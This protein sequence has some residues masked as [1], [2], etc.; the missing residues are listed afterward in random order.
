MKTSKRGLAIG[1]FAAVLSGGFPIY[2]GAQTS[3]NGGAVFAL[4]AGAEVA[5][6]AE[7]GLVTWM[8][9]ATGQ[10]LARSLAPAGNLNPEQAAAA[11]LNSQA[12]AFGLRTGSAELAATRS[13]GDDINHTFVRFQQQ[14]RDVPIIGAE[15]SVQLD[16]ARN[17]MSVNGKTVGDLDLSVQ[18]DVSA[19]DAL[20]TAL[21]STARA[22]RVTVNDL[23]GST[24]KLSIH[25]ARIMGGPPAPPALVWRI[26]VKGV[27]AID[28][29]ELVLVNAQNGRVAVQFNQT[30][31]A[32]LPENAKQ[33]VCDAANTT[34]KVPCTKAD[35]VTAPGSSAVGDV[36]NAF[37]YAEFTYDF[38]AKRFNRNSLDNKGLRLISTTRYRDPNHPSS[39][40]A[41][42]FWSSDIGQM[43]YGKDYASAID[44]V[45]HELSHG[46]T[47][48][49]S[50]LFYYYQSGAINESLSD[51][52]GELIQRA[53]DGSKEFLMGEDLPIGAIRS[54]KDPT[55]F[56]DPDKMTSTLWTGDFSFTDQGGVHR[57]SGV[58]NKTAYLIIKG[59][60]FNGRKITGLGDNKAAAIYYR[61]NSLLLQSAS[62]YADLGNALKQACKDLIGTKPKNKSGNPTAAITSAD[63]SQVTKV[64]AATELNKKP[65]Y[66]PIPA[67]A[68]VCAAN[69]KMV[70]T[71]FEKFEAA[72][73]A[74]F[75][76]QP[77]DG[78]HWS[79][80][81]YYA[82]SNSHAVGAAG[83]GQFDT[84]IASTTATVIPAKAFLRFAHFYNLY[85]SGGISYA[86]G[87]VEYKIGNGQWKMVPASMFTHNRYNTTLQSG[88]GNVLAGK[89]AFSGFSGG[90]TSSRIDLSSLK[91]KSVSFRFRLGTDSKGAY[92]GW[93]IDDIRIY[94][95]K[96][97]PAVTASA[98]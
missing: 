28:I 39:D 83:S 77:S 80:E 36:K 89:K 16:G 19:A 27:S 68:P 8:S 73:P 26:D 72:N 59:G 98:Q 41:N 5:R 82:A 11:F 15:L 92:D 61:V 50:A 37:H 81:D 65:Q 96:A 14:Y 22:H 46:F 64:V 58:G 88:T 30:P 55:Q 60:T 18:P 13:E 17:V 74:K 75:K 25:D 66:W 49:T 52:F 91:G 33:W 90:W 54:M 3:G 4:Q 86:G 34:G 6:H 32:A 69:Q 53:N 87:V 10:P 97:A 84:N 79:L 63:C 42:A 70:N 38:Y 51:V 12:T 93:L 71:S 20:R 62:D 29:D 48:F 7:T 47:S 23:R 95:C 44:V 31:H 43:V 40:Y 57:N 56:G 24:P 85:T 78:T 45:G 76:Y 21:A 94:T 2:A 35:V 67:E 1:V 9:G